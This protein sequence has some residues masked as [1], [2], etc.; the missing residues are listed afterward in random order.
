MK[1]LNYIKTKKLFIRCDK[2]RLLHLPSQNKMYTK[3]TPKA[4]SKP[5]DPKS[6]TPVITRNCQM[7]NKNPNLLNIKR[8]NRLRIASPLQEM[9]TKP[10]L[11]GHYINNNV[12]QNKF[13][14]K[15]LPFE[16]I[17][18]LKIK[19]NDEPNNLNKT[20][21]K[22]LNIIKKQFNLPT[23]Q[24]INSFMNKNTKIKINNIN[25]YNNLKQ[26]FND[27]N[28][29]HFTENEKT[30]EKNLLYN[31]IKNP[32]YQLL[33]TKG[34]STGS[35]LETREMSGNTVIKSKSSLNS[36]QIA[37]LNTNTKIFKE[38]CRSLK[39]LFGNHRTIENSSIAY[40]NYN[41]ICKQKI[42]KYLDKTIKDL[43][44]IK[45]I[46]LDDKEID[47]YK[48]DYE[49]GHNDEIKDNKL[50][51]IN[52]NTKNYNSRK[53]NLNIDT[54]ININYNLGKDN[55]I[56]KLILNK[57]PSNIFNFAKLHKT[58][59]YD[60]LKFDVKEKEKYSGIERKS[61]NNIK[62][63]VKNRRTNSS[64]NNQYNTINCDNEQFYKEDKFSYYKNNNIVKNFDC[65]VVIPNLNIN[66]E[67]NFFKI[68][69]NEKNKNQLT[70]DRYIEEDNNCNIDNNELA[71]FE[72]LD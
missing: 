31:D 43:K 51:K 66:K 27:D 48:E 11:K 56:R 34:S 24:N 6:F 62:K 61:F 38:R 64:I 29:I 60:E 32:L 49:R 68:N 21:K 4:N 44:K 54:K 63:N 20:K 57:S 39:N 26:N 25:K 45:T 3:L 58:I 41:N 52:L 65:E 50:K 71:N 16:K 59:S 53:N 17:R 28:L 10:F 46:I 30:S 7:I 13:Q 19:L 12:N 14:Y 18:R 8:N 72:F 37:N 15:K 67:N 23:V 35:K 42:I 2:P 55:K 33:D 9:N 70:K 1:R 40:M 5:L 36:P 47:E 69:E 22:K